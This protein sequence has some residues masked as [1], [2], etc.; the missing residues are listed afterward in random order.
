MEHQL[1]PTYLI[2]LPM[3]S[4]ELCSCGSVGLVS[5]IIVS[6]PF[7]SFSKLSTG[8]NGGSALSADLRAAHACI[9]TNLAASVGGLTWMFWVNRTQSV[10]SSCGWHEWHQDYRTER[11]W[12]AVGFCSGAIAALVAITPGSGYVGLREYP[13]I[14]VFLHDPNSYSH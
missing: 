10:I 3:W 1:L 7:R 6:Q 12:S 8:F 13:H 5:L 11:K 14:S 9:A 2:T 4:L